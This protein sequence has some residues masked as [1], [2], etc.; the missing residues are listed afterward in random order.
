MYG[1]RLIVVEYY[2]NLSKLRALIYL[3]PCLYLTFQN[4]LDILY[5]DTR[6]S[7]LIVTDK[8]QSVVSNREVSW[9]KL[10]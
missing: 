1:C 4:S 3:S 2:I 9:I 8:C 7:I 5:S 6:V 10:V